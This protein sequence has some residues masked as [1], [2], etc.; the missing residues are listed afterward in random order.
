MIHGLCCDMRLVQIKKKAASSEL[1]PVVSIQRSKLIQ[2]QLG[3]HVAYITS[4]IPSR[5]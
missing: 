5:L 3:P 1:I 2:N 4:L